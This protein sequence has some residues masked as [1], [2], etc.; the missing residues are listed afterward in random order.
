MNCQ[1][2]LL[3]LHWRYLNETQYSKILTLYQKYWQYK[4]EKIL[5]N[6]GRIFSKCKHL[7]IGLYL[8]T[9]YMLGILAKIIEVI[10]KPINTKY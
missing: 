2:W 1:Y 5:F 3:A 10:N 8:N 6:V 7:N 9:G 4:S